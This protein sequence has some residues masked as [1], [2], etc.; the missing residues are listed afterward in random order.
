MDFDERAYMVDPYR[1][2]FT[3]RVREVIDAGEGI[4]AVYLDRTYFYPV[5][6]GQP[7]DRGTLGG[8]EVTGVTEDERGVRHLVGGGLEPGAEVEGHIDWTRRFDHMQQHS[9]Q[10]ILSR[11][12]VDAHGLSTVGFH[13]GER[14]ST[15]DLDGDI[16]SPEALA[17]VECLVNELIWRDM[18]IGDRIVGREEYERL[19]EEQTGPGMTVRSRLPEGVE[20]I[21][22]VEVE[23]V[24]TTTCCGTH[25]RS[26]GEIGLIKILG[27]ERVRQTVRVEFICG[28]RAL[29]DYAEKHELVSSLARGFTTDW[30]E[31]PTIVAKTVDEN[32][33]LRKAQEAL[34]RELSGFRAGE[35]A[36][37]VATI[38]GIDIIRRVMEEDIGSLRDMAFSMREE[39]RRVILFGVS[40]SKPGLLFACSQDLTLD[41]GEV[42]RRSAPLMEARGGGGKDFAQGGGG[43]A[44]RIDAALDEAERA[45]REALE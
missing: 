13:L 15:I 28:G 30:Q 35:L 4:T 27:T 21:R 10:H 24:D 42:M 9:G 31:L 11:V 36:K 1:T 38:A 29:S 41:M 16:D 23:G 6:G 14:T 3:A 19:Q 20:R 40:G 5:S 44:Q 39:G 17:S 43:D 34:R 45:V 32:K 26:S 25:C 18:P 22:L 2:D 12:F 8:R 7:D 37:P 33:E